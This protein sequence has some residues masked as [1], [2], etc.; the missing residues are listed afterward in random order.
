MDVRLWTAYVEGPTFRLPWCRSLVSVSAVLPVL[1]A[2]C[3]FG[4]RAEACAKPTANQ[5]RG[6]SL[7]DGRKV[8]S[9]YLLILVID[10]T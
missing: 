4:L 7:L 3:F 1:P 6:N 8:A 5:K 9:I 10:S 2:P